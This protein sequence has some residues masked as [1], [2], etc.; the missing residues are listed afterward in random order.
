MGIFLPSLCLPGPA[1][2]AE[3][4]PCLQEAELFHSPGLFCFSG[5]R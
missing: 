3:S 4:P 5:N 2:G 1:E